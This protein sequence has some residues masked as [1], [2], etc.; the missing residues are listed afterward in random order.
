[1]SHYCEQKCWIARRSSCSW[2]SSYSKALYGVQ[3][4]SAKKESTT[5]LRIVVHAPAIRGDESKPQILYFEAKILLLALGQPA[6]LRFGSKNIDCR[7]KKIVRRV[8]QQLRIE[9]LRRITLVV[10]NYVSFR[11]DILAESNNSRKN[12]H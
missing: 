4:D 11:N 10:G 3:S 9:V 6:R 7:D 8:S 12:R 1:M 5:S 2:T